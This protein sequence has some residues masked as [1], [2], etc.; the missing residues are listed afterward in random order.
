VTIGQPEEQA[1]AIQVRPGGLVTVR[2]TTFAG[3]DHWVHPATL[4]QAGEGLVVTG[5]SAGLDIRRGNGRTF[6]SPYDTNGHYWPDRWFNVIRLELPGKGLFGY[7][8][9]I[10]TPVQFD[11]TTVGYVDLQLDVIARVTDEGGLSYWL[12]D[13]DEFEEARDRYG[14]DDALISRCYAAVEEVSR[15]IEGR[16][17]PFDRR[18]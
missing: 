14:Y 17:F 18:A 12:A 5:T 7:Y 11:G 8:C 4:V 15:L 13:E 9:N 16:A 3:A 6:T 10:A 1:R 2:A